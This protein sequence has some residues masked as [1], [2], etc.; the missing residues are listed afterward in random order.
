MRYS[1][2]RSGMNVNWNFF[3]CFLS[4]V[5]HDFVVFHHQPEPNP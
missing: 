1:D 5:F 3:V 4:F 2:H